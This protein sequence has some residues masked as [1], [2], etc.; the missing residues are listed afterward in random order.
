MPKSKNKV[1]KTPKKKSSGV[2]YQKKA[3]SAR[4][5]IKNQRK[6]QM[7]ELGL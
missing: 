1:K 5:A 2:G 3:K 6:R 4:D 7:K